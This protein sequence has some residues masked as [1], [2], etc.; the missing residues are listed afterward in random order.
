[1]PST[2]LLQYPMARKLLRVGFFLRTK[3]GPFATY[4][5][6]QYKPTYYLELV[7]MQRNKCTINNYKSKGF[8]NIALSR[9]NRAGKILRYVVLVL[10]TVY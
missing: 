9:P 4:S 6:V 2:L 8:R 1:M 5:T 10:Y 3:W 7:H